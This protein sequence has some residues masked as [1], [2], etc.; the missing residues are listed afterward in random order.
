MRC[1]TLIAG[2]TVR[3]T[4]SNRDAIGA[5]I[6]IVSRHQAQYNHTT[7]SVGYASSSA[8]PVHFELGADSAA[9]SVEIHW[10]SGIVQQ[11]RNVTADRVVFCDRAG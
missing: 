3:G 7:T 5:R 8:G 4:K 9:D 2:A 6:Q 1:R 10:P 11:L